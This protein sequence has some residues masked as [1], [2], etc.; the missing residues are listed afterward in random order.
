VGAAL[1]VVPIPNKAAIEPTAKKTLENQVG[2]DTSSWSPDV[3]VETFLA[4]CKD[5][6]IPAI[7][8][9][10]ALRAD[11]PKVRDGHLYYQKDWHLNAEGN[12]TLARFVHDQLDTSGAFPA[13]FVATRK[14]ELPIPP[15]APPSYGPVKLFAF[16]WALLS[17]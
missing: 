12:R 4:L 14:S 17:I 1:C 6:G 9:R 8:P 2:V 7:D 15:D 10:D 11:V 16:L 3:P 13:A 5:L